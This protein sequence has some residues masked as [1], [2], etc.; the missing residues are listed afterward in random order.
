M[1]VTGGS[2]PKTLVYWATNID[3]S[4]KQEMNN[5]RSQIRKTA[6]IITFIMLGALASLA[7]GVLSLNKI[8]FSMNLPAAI[9]CTALGSLLILINAPDV[10]KLYDANQILIDKAKRFTTL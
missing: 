7:I 9:T 2:S 3:E 1:C 6:V 8:Y 10:K 5:C 4:R